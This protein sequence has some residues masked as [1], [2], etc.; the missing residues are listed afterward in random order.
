M[1]SIR[2]I[3][4]SFFKF[5]LMFLRDIRMLGLVMFLRL[6]KRFIVISNSSSRW[7][8]CRI[9]DLSIISSRIIRIFRALRTF[10]ASKGSSNFI[11][12]SGMTI[13]NSSYS[14]NS[15]NSLVSRIICINSRWCS[16]ITSSN[17]LLILIRIV[18]IDFRTISHSYLRIKDA[19]INQA[20]I[21]S[22]I[23]PQTFGGNQTS[24]ILN[25]HL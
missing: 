1:R 25:T 11:S 12:H 10:R 24:L 4:R 3:G 17:T 8:W 2:V 14:S 21:N 22:H 9:I 18:F 6:L 13:I 19:I 7:W 20:I 5:I 15:N 16:K 23:T